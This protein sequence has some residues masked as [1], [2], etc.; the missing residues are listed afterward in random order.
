M[1]DGPDALLPMI[2]LYPDVDGTPTVQ[3]QLAFAGPAD[4]G[5]AYA[6]TLLGEDAVRHAGLRPGTYLD[7]QN[8]N[9][10]E[11]FGR[12]NYW[13][14]TFVR[15]L[16]DALIDLLVDVSAAFP[17]G[18]SGLL[19]EP[20]HGVARR[21]SLDHAAFQHRIARFHVSAIAI[22]QDPTM[23]ATGTAWSKNVTARVAEWS[24][25]GLYVNYA[26]PGEAASTAPVDRARAAYPAA[27][28]ERLRAV[29]RRYDPDNVFRSNLNIPPA[30]D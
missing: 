24:A 21:T 10:I 11:D 9:P 26:M 14:S 17:S 18:E 8:I 13:T 28:Y 29:K 19:I 6:T 5:A 1:R 4:E 22:W 2:V 20:V 16:D 3:V 12:R 30:D 27:T 15:D 7:I 25:G 23:D